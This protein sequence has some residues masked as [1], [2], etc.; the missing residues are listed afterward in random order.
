MSA[1]LFSF[2]LDLLSIVVD[3]SA[4]VHGCNK[5]ESFVG[6]LASVRGHKVATSR[7]DGHAPP[8]VDTVKWS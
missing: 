5:R 6:K 2:D 7:G 1:A 4:I 8:G 3:N